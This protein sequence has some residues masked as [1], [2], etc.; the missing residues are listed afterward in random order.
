MGQKLILQKVVGQRDWIHQVV[1]GESK[2]KFMNINNMVINGRRS[3]KKTLDE[4]RDLET[5]SD[6]EFSYQ[7]VRSTSQTSQASLE[8]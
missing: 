3:I 8:S 4:A 1:V 2:A 5:S 6:E 7:A